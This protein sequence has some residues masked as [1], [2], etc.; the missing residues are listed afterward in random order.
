MT[1]RET[2]DARR[3][4]DTAPPN[5]AQKYATSSRDDTEYG[6]VVCGR[7]AAAFAGVHVSSFPLPAS[8]HSRSYRSLSSF[9]LAWYGADSSSVSAFHAAPISFDSSGII[10]SGFA[11]L[12]SSRWSLQ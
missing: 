6:T 1:A 7:F 10:A 3:L 2:V 4:V 12:N 9:A 11:A 8:A 5:R